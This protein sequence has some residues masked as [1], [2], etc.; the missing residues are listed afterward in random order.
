M[1]RILKSLILLWNDAK[2]NKKIIGPFK[3]IL[4]VK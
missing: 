4:N 2:I 3:N 1:L